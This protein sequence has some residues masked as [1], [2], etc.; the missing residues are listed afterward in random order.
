[1]NPETLPS[2]SWRYGF[3][4]DR[5]V[6]RE[7]KIRYSGIG[8][9]AAASSLHQQARLASFGQ[10][11]SRL[12]ERADGKKPWRAEHP[13]DD[14]AKAAAKATFAAAKAAWRL[15]GLKLEENHQQHIRALK[16]AL[17]TVGPGHQGWYQQRL[18]QA[19]DAHARLAA[20]ETCFE[21]SR[22]IAGCRDFVKVTDERAHGT[23]TPLS[24]KPKAEAYA[25]G[26]FTGAP[27]A[28]VPACVLSCSRATAVSIRV[29]RSHAG[30]LGRAGFAF[31]RQLAHD[32]VTECGDNVSR[33]LVCARGG[34]AFRVAASGDG[35]GGQG[36]HVRATATLI[37]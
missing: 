17:D 34:F 12:Y 11:T 5:Q 4:R 6:I 24:Q 8:G 10:D 7:K 16:D 15:D 3:P 29:A 26:K 30:A 13:A 31:L 37:R 1:M 2:F 23:R 18:K 28:C 33:E 14:E 22:A 21:S 20:F 35:R 25:P 36:R 27:A 32:G 9:M 19:E